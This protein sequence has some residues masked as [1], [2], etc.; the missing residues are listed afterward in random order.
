MMQLNRRTVLAGGAALLA[1]S[2]I[3]PAFA[4]GTGNIFVSTEK[5]NE[6][7]VLDPTYKIIKRIATARRP[8]HM[9]F[10]KAHYRLYVAWGDDD[11]IDVI[12]VAKLEVIDSIPTG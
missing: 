4:A 3:R 1:A 9:Q 5:G 2:A 10:S 6:V 11:S 12:D 7:V 8:R